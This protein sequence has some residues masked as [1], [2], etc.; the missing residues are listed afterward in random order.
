VLI[1]ALTLALTTQPPP[2]SSPSGNTLD[3]AL[4]STLLAAAPRWTMPQ[5]DA[6]ARAIQD[7]G[8]PAELVLGLIHTESRFR[9]RAESGRGA[10]GVMQ[11]MPST[12]RAFAARAGVVWR[13]LETLDDPAASVRIGATYLRHLLDRF[14]GDT[15]LALAAYSHGPTRVRRA[16]RAHGQLSARA[17]GYG[18][19]V[20]Q[21]EAHYA[22]ALVAYGAVTHDDATF[23]RSV[24]SDPPGAREPVR[25]STAW[26][27]AP[28]STHPA[29]HS[30]DAAVYAATDRASGRAPRTSG[31]RDHHPALL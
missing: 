29:L 7:S 4:R 3:S 30:V 6:V 22:A 19:R 26:S 18:R 2:S 27:P 13:G 25:M 21:H 11:L 12:A 31:Q 23:S 15:T 9:R 28:H 17:H 1:L 10:R 24:A 5:I 8:L 14:G 20:R 16:L